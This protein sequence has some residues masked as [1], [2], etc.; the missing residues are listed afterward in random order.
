[1]IES[2]T[3]R[4]LV[5]R[6]MERPWSDWAAA[7]PHLAAAIDRSRLIE[8]TVARLR[9]DPQVERAMREADLSASQLE[10][11]ARVL[12]RLERLVGLALPMG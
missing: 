11:A 1:M 7:H 4:E 10:A 5:E 8:Q 2:R 9:E 12:E 6:R 3:L